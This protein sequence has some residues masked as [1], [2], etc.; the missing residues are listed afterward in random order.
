MISFQA[1]LTGDEALQSK[2][3]QLSNQGSRRAMRSALMV[4]NTRFR[5]AIVR[6]IP[7]A[8]TP[9]HDNANFKA[10]I[11]SRLISSRA[12]GLTEAKSGVGVAKDKLW[13]QKR[14]V[15]PKGKRRE[16]YH[17]HRSQV[18]KG[19]NHFHLLAMGTTVRRTAFGA[20]RGSVK[21]GNYVPKAAAKEGTAAGL[22]MEL[23]LRERIYAEATKEG[24]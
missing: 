10:N 23:K 7:P 24:I 1:I 8:Q 22:A 6:E 16:A 18:R 2:F 11:G 17:R 21:A 5:K 13:V 9:G 20:N 19:E 14:K 3:N 15:I 12:Q 4:G